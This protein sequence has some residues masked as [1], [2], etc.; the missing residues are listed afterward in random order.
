MLNK[1]DIFKFGPKDNILSNVCGGKFL[2][3][4]ARLS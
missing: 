1:V 2:N 3:L 4:D